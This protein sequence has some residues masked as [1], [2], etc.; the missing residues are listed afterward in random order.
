MICYGFADQNEIKEMC[1]KD[2]DAPASHKEEGDMCYNQIHTHD[3]T[4]DA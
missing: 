1:S 4:L 2:T 3:T